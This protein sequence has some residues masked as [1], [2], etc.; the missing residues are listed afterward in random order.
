MVYAAVGSKRLP[1]RPS[2]LRVTIESSPYYEAKPHE[3]AGDNLPILR[4]DFPNKMKR[5]SP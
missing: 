2:S 5:W 1:L 3:E 4:E